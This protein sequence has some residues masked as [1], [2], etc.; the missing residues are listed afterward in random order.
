[1]TETN[2]TEIIEE[3]I[4]FGKKGLTNKH[5]VKRCPERWL[6][7]GKYNDKPLDPDYFK[8]YW[9]EHSNKEYKCPICERV[10]FSCDKIK[11][12]E[13]SKVCLRAQALLETN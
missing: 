9:R 3:Q 1:M 6:P 7:D 8:K 4:V 2:N 5:K 10:I 12:H 13:K 11:R